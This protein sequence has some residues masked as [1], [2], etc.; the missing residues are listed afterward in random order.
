MLNSTFVK[1]VSWYGAFL[2]LISRSFFVYEL[3]LCDFEL[4]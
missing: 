4:R 1:L 3:T 2:Q